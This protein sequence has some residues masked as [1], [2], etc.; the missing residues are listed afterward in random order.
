[1]EALKAAEIIRALAEGRDPITGEKFPPDSPYQQAD[2]VRALFVAL[3]V[4]KR[5]KH[6]RV[7]RPVDPNRPK[8]GASWTPDEEQQLRDEFAAQK[9]IPELAA[10]HGRTPG[11]IT[12]RLVRMGLIEADPSDHSGRGNRSPGASPPAG[13]D[14]EATPF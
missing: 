5:Q 4:L 14:G 12:A 10:M 6:V 1:M 13:A 9:T 7:K 2:T 11:A 8:M 3:E